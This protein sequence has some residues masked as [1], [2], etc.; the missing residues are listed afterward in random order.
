MSRWARSLYE[1]GLTPGQVLHACY[2]VHFPRELFAVAESDPVKL[3]LP[4]DFT[5]QPWKLAVPLPRGGPR[6]HPDS[7]ES[8]EHTIYD[9]DPDL[10]PLALF[11]DSSALHGGCLVCYRLTELSAGR[12]TVF[13]VRRS[14]SPGDQVRPVA[15]SFLSAMHAHLE[16]IHHQWE[17]RLELDSNYGNGSIDEASVNEAQGWVDRVAAIQR[18]VA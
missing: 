2:D 18:R 3:S 15:E 4:V 11:I 6:P 16:D 13:A 8:F 17:T 9:R 1:R 12:S 10:V 5:N 14:L 7:M